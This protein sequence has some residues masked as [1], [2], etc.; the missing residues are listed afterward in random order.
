MDN[1]NRGGSPG[2]GT[3]F[4]ITKS[5]TLTTRHSFC[6]PKANGI[7]NEKVLHHFNNTNADGVNPACALIFDSVGK[8]YGTTVFGGDVGAGTVFGLTPKPG[9]G[10]SERC[11]TASAKRRTT[12]I[13]M[14]A[15]FSIPL[16]A[17][18]VP[19]PASSAE[20]RPTLP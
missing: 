9:G 17:S 3:V 19:S 13:P 15:W 8:L 20:S 16:A 7:W 10:W 2:V 12:R 14:L 5:G 4:R 11:C 6:Q 1:P 18:T